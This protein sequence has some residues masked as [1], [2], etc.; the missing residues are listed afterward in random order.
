[1]GPSDRLLLYTDGLV[2]ARAANGNYFDLDSQAA[3]A[4]AARSL[5]DALDDLVRR[6][7][8]HVGGQ[9]DDDMALVLAQPRRLVSR[10]RAA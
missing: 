2:E 7:L 6:V 5:S 3:A 9:L 1:M 10:R 8:K 4:L